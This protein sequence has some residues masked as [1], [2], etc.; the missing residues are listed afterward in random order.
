MTAKEYLNQAYWL[1][2][3][4]DSKL[5]QLSALKDMA[6]K[7]TSIMSDDVV[8]HTRNVH[9]MQDVIAKIIDMQ[10]EINAD[11]DR[12]VDLKQDIMQVVKTVDDPELQTLLELRYLCF[13]DWQDIAYSMHF[14]ESNVFK[15]HSK[16]LQAVKLPKLG[17]EFQ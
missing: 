4:I 3:R 5:E 15:V 10:A 14:T 11:I 1:D 2:R 17:S 8:S 16:A 6:T 12:L 13:K 7:T 9:S